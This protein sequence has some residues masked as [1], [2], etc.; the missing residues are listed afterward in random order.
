MRCTS[1]VFPRF[2]G[3][4]ALQPDPNYV[5]LSLPFSG[6]LMMFG[7]YHTEPADRFP[8]ANLD[9]M[10]LYKSGQTSNTSNRTN[11]LQTN[12]CHCWSAAAAGNIIRIS[13]CIEVLGERERCKPFQFVYQ[14]EANNRRC[15]KAAAYS[16]S[17]SMPLVE[18][19]AAAFVGDVKALQLVCDASNPSHISYVLVG[20][21]VPEPIP[22]NTCTHSTGPQICALSSRRCRLEID[23]ICAARR[24]PAAQHHRAA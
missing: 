8:S 12:I 7:N 23:G 9:W 17:C 13:A 5:W 14:Q 15:L 10:I 4:D 2:L 6:Q 19:G 1:V 16:G 21:F 22:P 18:C 3:Q 20:T 24:H 11:A